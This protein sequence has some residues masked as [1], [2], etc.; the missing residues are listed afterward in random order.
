MRIASN[1]SKAKLNK[2]ALSLFLNSPEQAVLQRIPPP[3]L[4]VGVNSRIHGGDVC[5][6]GSCGEEGQ[7]GVTSGHRQALQEDV[8]PQP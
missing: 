1:A 7:P 8:T 2:R 5:S 3:H 6:H 4:Y